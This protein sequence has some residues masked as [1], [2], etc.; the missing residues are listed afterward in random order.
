[1]KQMQICQP[2]DNMFFQGSTSLYIDPERR[3][4]SLASEIPELQHQSIHLEQLEILQIERMFHD[5]S[6]L[7]VKLSAWS[8]TV[9]PSWN[10]V[11][12]LRLNDGTSSEY[13]PCIIHKYRHHYIARVWNFYRVS[14]LI[15]QSICL[16]ATVLLPALADDNEI[17]QKIASLVDDICATVPYL[18]GTDLCKMKL[19]STEN[20][21][22]QDPRL[23][24]GSSAKSKGH[25][26]VGRFSLIWP[27]F[28]ACSASRIPQV[29]KDWMRKQLQL[30]AQKGIPVAQTV[31]TIESQIL[32]GRPERFVFDC[33]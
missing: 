2:L 22:R 12:A 33:V 27:L 10:F 11:T 20:N 21:M 16:R 31:C 18:L 3:L 29:Q 23:I 26:H 4:I 14:Q 15:L 19:D 5:A 32:L 8:S 28:V 1:M 7:A 30:L 13:T 17:G 25:A 9:P 6:A 24:C